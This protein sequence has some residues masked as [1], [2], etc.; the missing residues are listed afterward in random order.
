MLLD[1]VDEARA[2]AVAHTCRRAI[3]AMALPH[4]QS[5]M[6]IV[7]VSI[8]LM[9]TSR[10]PSATRAEWLDR[11]DAAL[12]EAKRAGRNQ[13]RATGDVDPSR[14]PSR[15]AVQEAAISM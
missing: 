3:E 4:A 10:Y 5:P 15:L 8:G 13:V 14:G 6:G 11:A 9:H 1:D 7:T 2:L 12:Y